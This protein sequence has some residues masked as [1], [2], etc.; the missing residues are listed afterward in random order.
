MDKIS[1]TF[2]GLLQSSILNKIVFCY[3]SLVA[4]QNVLNS[5]REHVL[6]IPNMVPMDVVTQNCVKLE[7]LAGEHFL[8]CGSLT[9]SPAC[10]RTAKV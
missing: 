9:P 8:V 7:Y 10:C 5:C 4:R 3:F 1:E 6:D 2:V